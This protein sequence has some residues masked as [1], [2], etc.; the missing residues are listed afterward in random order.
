M[1]TPKAA[2]KTP[3]PDIVI[4]GTHSPGGRESHAKC[5]IASRTALAK[6]DITPT[7][8]ITRASPAKED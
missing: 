8:I 6:T 4:D 3:K 7:T 5:Q 1:S 2:E